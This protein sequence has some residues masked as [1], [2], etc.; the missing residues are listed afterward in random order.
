LNLSVKDEIL[1]GCLP[2][3]VGVVLSEMSETRC[4]LIDWSLEVE[5][6]H[7]LS[8][9]EAE[10]LFDNFG[11]IIISSAMFD[12]A[13]RL[14]VNAERIRKSNSITNLNEDAVSEVSSDH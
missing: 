1:L 5:F 4:F 10:I 8:G 6:L 13:V 2:G 7:N 11:Q 12:S 3:E 14:D 9:A